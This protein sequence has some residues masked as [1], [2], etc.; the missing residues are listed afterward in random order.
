MDSSPNRSATACLA[1]ERATNQPSTDLITR[2]ALREA[3]NRLI[4]ST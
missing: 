1:L 2:H 4:R 3:K